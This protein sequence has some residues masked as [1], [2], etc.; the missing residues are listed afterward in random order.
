MLYLAFAAVEVWVSRGYIFKASRTAVRDHGNYCTVLE[1]WERGADLFGGIFWSFGP[2]PMLAYRLVDSFL[3]SPILTFVVT[4]LLWITLGIFIVISLCTTRL[5]ILI[6]ALI[7]LNLFP[8]VEACTS[9]TWYPPEFVFIA[10]CGWVYQVRSNKRFMAC[11]AVLALLMQFN[12]Q[13]SPILL[14]PFLAERILRGKIPLVELRNLVITPVII[15]ALG[16]LAMLP[17]Y[18]SMDLFLQLNFPIHMLEQYESMQGKPWAILRDLDAGW[19]YNHLSIPTFGVLC[20]FLL[21]FLDGKSH[22]NLRIARLHAISGILALLLYCRHR[23]HYLMNTYQFY[24]AAALLAVPRLPRVRLPW[25]VLVLPAMALGLK[26]NVSAL[27]NPHPLGKTITP[28][29]TWMRKHIFETDVTYIEL[30]EAC[31]KNG[32]EKAAFLTRHPGLSYVISVQNTLPITWILA[33]WVHEKNQEDFWEAVLSAPW[34]VLEKTDGKQTPKANVT[35]W[36]T[37]PGALEASKKID[38]H[39]IIWENEAFLLLKK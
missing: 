5:G 13:T 11:L 30:Q 35:A 16:S 2:I 29:A 27:F 33:G 20:A 14:A 37:L 10:L 25:I 26:I 34:L 22:P 23:D 15:M 9:V 12:K 24:L 39:S 17:I 38:G 18:G 28:D 4:N 7:L 19:Y 36:N 32:V 6:A 3:Q 31:R 21:C 1:E 8:P